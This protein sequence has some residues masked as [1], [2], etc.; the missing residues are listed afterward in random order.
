M[1]TRRFTILLVA[2]VLALAGL[3][4]FSTAA[5]AQS[6]TV[7]VRLPSGEVVQVTVDVPPGG[8]LE[9]M[10]LPGTLVKDRTKTAQ[11]EVPAPAPEQPQEQTTPAPA[12]EPSPPSAG[13]GS[14][15][16]STNSGERV[17]Q[18]R[19]KARKITAGKPPV[20]DEGS[21]EKDS[22]LRKADGTPTSSNPGFIDALPGPSTA[23]GVPNFIIRKFRVPPFL[24]P[25]YQ[26]AGIEYGIRWEVL[27][28]IN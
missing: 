20:K 17:H 22:K 1:K 2:G 4:A 27:A 26:A 8:S 14:P 16:G 11:A 19:E 6:E 18:E 21:D 7:S 24:L 12:P 25:I 28:A 15:Q 13:G 23:H 3:T 10:K 5:S 9:D